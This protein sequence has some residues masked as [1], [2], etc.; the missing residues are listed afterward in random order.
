MADIPCNQACT[1]NEAPQAPDRLCNRQSTVLSHRYNGNVTDSEATRY[2]RP[3]CRTHKAICTSAADVHVGG[4]HHPPALTQ[5]IHLP[6]AHP[7]IPPAETVPSLY[8]ACGQSGA[9]TY[10]GSCL[11]FSDRCDHCLRASRD[12]RKAVQPSLSTSSCCSSG[13][14]LWS[15]CSPSSYE[16]ISR[17]AVCAHIA[18]FSWRL[19][20]GC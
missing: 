4:A 7:S 13:A 18:A 16:G 6:P 17:N 9:P 1:G 10:F 8:P 2:C 20:T 14:I 5:T 15:M 3:P 19:K 12:V 11:Q